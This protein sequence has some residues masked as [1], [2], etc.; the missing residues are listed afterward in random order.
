MPLHQLP[1]ADGDPRTY[2]DV[3][4]ALAKMRERRVVEAR[5]RRQIE[6]GEFDRARLAA[7]E[8]RDEIAIGGVPLRAIERAL[9]DQEGHPLLVAVEWNQ[10][11][12]EVE[13]GENVGTQGE[14]M[15]S[16]NDG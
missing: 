8:A 6:L 5:Q 12:V 7:V 4:V 10:R 9:V 1:R 2:F 16:Y 15:K 14:G 11:M 3:Q 13:D